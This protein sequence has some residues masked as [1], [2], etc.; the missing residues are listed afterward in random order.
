MNVVLR[1]LSTGVVPTALRPAPHA[2]RLTVAGPGNVIVAGSLSADF[3]CADVEGVVAAADDSPRG[4][5]CFSTWAK[6]EISTLDIVPGRP[7]VKHLG[8]VQGSTVRSGH[9][10][11]DLLAGLENL[12]GGEIR[13]YTLLLMESREEAIDRMVQQAR[14]I[15]ANAVLNIRFSTASVSQGAAE[16]LAYGTAVVLE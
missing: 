2:A 9:F 14:G 8:L 1:Q 13:Q 5:V 16:I 10:G 11:R 15:G 4:T 3:T 7:I 6:A 12:A